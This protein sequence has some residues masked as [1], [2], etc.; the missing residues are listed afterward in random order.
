MYKMESSCIKQ[1]DL[2]GTELNLNELKRF[3]CL[4]NGVSKIESNL[5]TPINPY[6]PEITNEFANLH[7]LILILF[8]CVQQL[9]TEIDS[10][11]ADKN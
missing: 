4:A 10:L 6:V 2:S 9:Q 11:K 3:P 8:K 7:N 5:N 1:L